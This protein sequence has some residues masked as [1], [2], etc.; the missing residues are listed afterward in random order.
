MKRLY[1]LKNIKIAAK[2]I[3]TLK[4]SLTV[5]KKHSFLGKRTFKITDV[6]IENLRSSPVM[7][8][9]RY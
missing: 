5:A 6:S 9:K 7:E 4:S 3:K 2:I 8:L 1:C